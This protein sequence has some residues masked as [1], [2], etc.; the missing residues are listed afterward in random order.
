MPLD[1]TVADLLAGMEA[2]GAPP[3]N[4]STVAE[5]REA[6]MLI[7]ALGGEGP[8]VAKEYVISAAGVRSVVYVPEEGVGPLPVLVYIHGGGFVIGSPESHAPT[9]RE[10]AVRAGCLVVS[11]DYRMGPEHKAPAAVE[12]SIA[13]TKW[14]IEHAAELGGDPARVAVGGDSAGGNLSALVALALPGRL[15]SQVL[16]YPAVDLTGSFPSIDENAEGY[17]LTKADMEWFM[18]HYLTGAEVK[19]DEPV[20]SPWFADDAALAATCPALVITA[21]FDPLRDEGE[22]YAK[23]LAELGVPTTLRRFDGMIHAFFGMTML[24]PQAVEANQLA[25]DHLRSAFS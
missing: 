15:V 21:E 25:A 17:F 2:S 11:I 16:I 23:R 19:A 13:A 3:L 12:D 1:P 9:C 14:V 7:A 6:I 8:A 22:A 10:L 24:L 5:G 20:V 4:E 18:G